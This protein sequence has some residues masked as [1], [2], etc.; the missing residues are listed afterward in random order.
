[1]KRVIWMPA[2]DELLPDGTVAY[3]W[4]EKQQ[5]GTDADG[6]PVYSET[7]CQDVVAAIVPDGFITDGIVL[8][9]PA[10]GIVASK[11][12]VHTFAGW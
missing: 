12:L 4:C 3:R 11:P 7:N 5:T 10:N 9:D 6:F 2:V 8:H 1:M